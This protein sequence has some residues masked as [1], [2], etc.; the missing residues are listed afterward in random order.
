MNALAHPI[1]T[2]DRFER[3]LV[4]DAS[5]RKAILVRCDCG[6]E[7]RVTAAALYSG[8]TRSCGCLHREAARERG[9]NNRKLAALS[10]GDVFGRMTVID[11]SDRSAVLLQ[12][13]CGTRRRVAAYR[14]VSG[15]VKSCG[16]LRREGTRR[17]HGL[18]D[19]ELYPTWQGMWARCTKPSATGYRDY[20]GRGITICEAWRDPAVFVSEIEAEIGK[21]P[22]GMTLDRI[23]NDGN[24]EPR[25]V[26]WATGG[27]QAI[28]RRSTW[29][30][31]V[32]CPACGHAFAVAD[33][34]TPAS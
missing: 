6:G 25:N 1:S 23:D 21:R 22:A 26:R 9:R 17:S 10:T 8:R 14:V 30:E 16:C 5:D 18:T 27:E 20:G 4:F 13:A 19:H 3:L 34:K 24:Y 15:H 31:R 33:G 32:A 29:R 11:P 2:G 28:N 12:C 7:K